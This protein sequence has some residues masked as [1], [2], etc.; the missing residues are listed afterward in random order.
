MMNTLSLQRRAIYRILA[1]FLGTFFIVSAVSFVVFDRK[2]ESKLKSSLITKK[3]IV[4]DAFESYLGRSEY[5]MSFIAQDLILGNYE[6]KKALDVLFGHHDLLFFGGL[7]FFYIDWA[8]RAASVDPRARLYT[9]DDIPSLFKKAKIN[10]WVK[11]SSQDGAIL[12]VYKKK[13]EGKQKGFLGYLYGFISLND[14]LTLAS[15]LLDS[16]KVDMVVIRDTKTGDILLKEGINN[17]SL[18]DGVVSATIA[19]STSIYDSELELDV[20]NS[21][22]LPN[23]LLYQWVTFIV[24]AF[25]ALTALYICLV[26]LVR[27]LVF[28]PLALAVGEANSTNLPF[29][30]LEPLQA[31]SSQYHQFLK[32]KERRFK[33]LLESSNNAVIFCNE[34]ATVGTIN[35]EAMR[36]FP[37]YKHARSVFDFTP[38]SCHQSI[39]DALKGEVGVTFELTFTQLNVMYQWRAYSFI[40]ENGFRSILLIGRDTTHEKRLSWQ[41]EQLKPSS[42]QLHRHI[43]VDVLLDELILLSRWPDSVPNEYFRGWLSVLLTLLE[44]LKAEDV[45]QCEQSVGELLANEY[46]WLISHLGGPSHIVHIDCSVA[47]GSFVIDVDNNLRNLL[48]VLL[49]LM[50][51]SDVSQRRLTV[52]F[53]DDLEIIISSD[54]EIRPFWYW[55]I[56]ALLHPL[57]GRQRKLRNN[58]FKVDLPLIKKAMQSTDLTDSFTVAWVF[59]DYPEPEKIKESL[60]RLGGRVDAYLSTD[61]F[62]MQASTV[63]Q[64]DV[65]LIGSDEDIDAQRNMTKALKGQQGRDELPVVWLGTKLCSTIERGVLGIFGY[66]SDYQLYQVIAQACQFDGITPMYLGSQQQAWIIVGGSRVSKAIWYSELERLSVSSQWLATLSE[67]GAIFPYHPDAVVVLL[68]PQPVELLQSIQENFPNVCFYAVQKWADMPDNVRLFEMNSPFS[69]EQISALKH[70]VQS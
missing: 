42:L 40:N 69:G 67:Y 10:R 28:K 4:E 14:N 58:V 56:N 70:H 47:V 20:I 57:N 33:L 8:H 25:I 32:A 3:Q 38:I 52:E 55:M 9:K 65:I 45:D 51:A 2:I 27:R 5:E 21:D 13:L 43:E 60:L 16:A 17:M 34:V 26:L 53:D 23:S 66:V 7:D 19:L 31:Q 39:Q 62:F 46:E 15:K 18:S 68:E 59:N 63:T 11:V 1:L 49:M 29:I 64:F 36:L 30:E 61:A 24:W 37:N 12:L 22:S 48:R 50:V 35:E 54:A 44:D 6:P 41:L